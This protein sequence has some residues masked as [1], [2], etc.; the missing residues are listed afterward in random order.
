ME[1]WETVKKGKGTNI[2]IKTR[3]NWERKNY[4]YKPHLKAL[5]DVKGRG[6]TAKVH[7]SRQ[8]QKWTKTNKGNQI[9]LRRHI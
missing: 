1:N 6:G 5:Y 2:Y 7:G 8:G 3:V 9:D 4:T